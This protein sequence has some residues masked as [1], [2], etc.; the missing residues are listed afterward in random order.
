VEKARDLLLRH[1]S[2]DT[3]VVVGRDVGGPEESV[4]VVRLADLDA[5]TVDMRCLL[6]I[7]SSQ[8]RVSARGTV[9]TPRRY[10]G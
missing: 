1:R 3:P 10:P 8:T 4:R 9:F 7:G 5:S 2:P 6:L